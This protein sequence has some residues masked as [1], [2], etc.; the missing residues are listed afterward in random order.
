VD[1]RDGTDPV[2]GRDTLLGIIANL[3]PQTGPMRVAVTDVH[4]KLLSDTTA[5]V[6]LTATIERTTTT[7]ERTLDA[8]EF[9]LEMIRE[10]LWRIRRVN[11]VDTLR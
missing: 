4:V 10:G 1:L 6:A 2:R 3:A 9:S 11:A 7:G 8:R 5:D